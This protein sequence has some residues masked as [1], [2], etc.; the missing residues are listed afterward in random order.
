MQQKIKQS[1]PLFILLSLVATGKEPTHYGWNLANTPLNIGGYLDLTYN[2]ENQNQLIFD[3]LALLLSANEAKWNLLGEIEL[4]HLPLEE[5]QLETYD[6][7]LNL[8][9]FQLSYLL[10]DSSSIIVGRFNSDIGYYNQAPVKFIQSTTTYPHMVEYLFPRSTTGIQ[11]I[12]H[13]PNDATLSFTLQNNPDIGEADESI[14]SDQ[15]FAISLFYPYDLISWRMAGGIYQ[16][17]NIQENRYYF[18]VG[19]E[20][21]GELV[22][23]Q[24]ELFTQ[25]RPNSASTQP[26]S[27]YIQSTWHLHENH[28]ATLRVEGYQDPLQRHIQE[29]TLLIGY[30][31]RPTGHLTIKGE[32]LYHTKLP[33]SRFISS[34]SVMF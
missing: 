2:E 18:G 30:S 32:Y 31:Y 14:Q 13:F 4:S 34:F 28:D 12:N 20:Y 1:L 15:H 26:Y 5:E 8:E 19:S 33:L 7:R 6:M 27:G 16:E 10:N 25:K 11:Y 21:D 9:R 17:H 3:D 23:I 22:N 29:Q 24:A